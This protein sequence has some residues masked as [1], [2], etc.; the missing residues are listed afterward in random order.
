MWLG[1][2]LMKG[3]SNGMLAQGQK[4]AYGQRSGIQERINLQALRSITKKQ[5]HS[6]TI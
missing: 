3:C 6:P 5:N 1:L 2:H 4:M